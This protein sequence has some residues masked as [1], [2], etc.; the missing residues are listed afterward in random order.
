MPVPVPDVLRD[1]TALKPTI[2]CSISASE[3]SK[4]PLP[5]IWTANLYSCLASSSCNFLSA[6]FA[7][8]I[9]LLSACIINQMSVQC[10]AIKVIRTSELEVWENY[11]STWDT[12][13]FKAVKIVARSR[14]Y[15]FA[16]LIILLIQTWFS[17]TDQRMIP[18]GSKQYIFIR[19]MQP[20]F[21]TLRPCV[22]ANTD[23]SLN[24][25]NESAGLYSILAWS[26]KC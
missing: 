5:T 21:K 15:S 2:L 11:I 13:C 10:L 24:F 22:E 20:R 12:G 7:A 26:H 25:S 18:V 9:A 17:Q 4:S 8:L 6:R 16:P 3:I 23:S 1:Y 19:Q 14:P